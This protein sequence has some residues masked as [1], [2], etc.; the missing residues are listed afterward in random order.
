AKIFLEEGV[1]RQVQMQKG[2]VT[3]SNLLVCHQ[4]DNTSVGWIKSINLLRHLMDFI[5]GCITSI[6]TF[7]HVTIDLPIFIANPVTIALLFNIHGSVLIPQADC[8]DHKVAHELIQSFLVSTCS[9]FCLEEPFLINIIIG[10][11]RNL[12]ITSI[13]TGNEAPS[14]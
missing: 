10:I 1:G 5:F 11:S 4:L 6:W 14:T 13:H 12:N 9:I 3:E 7:N 8:L 2:G